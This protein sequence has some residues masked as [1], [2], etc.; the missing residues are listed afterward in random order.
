M[1][2]TSLQQSRILIIDDGVDDVE[3]LRHILEQD[4]YREIQSTTDPFAA[5]GLFG[6]FQPDLVVL[7]LLMP[8]L[9]GLKVL[10]E[11]RAIIPAGTHL[12]ILVVTADPT[13]ETR[14]EALSHG[15]SDFVTKPYDTA[16][17]R[18]RIGNHLVT[19]LLH[20]QLS[21]KQGELTVANEQ[22]L[23]EVR[24]RGQAEE[25]LR[26][27]EEHLRFTLEAT[28]VGEWELDLV[29]GASRRS[30]RHDQIFGY[31]HL[32][33]GWNY[34][35]F[36]QKHVHSDD[37]LRVE[38]SFQ[39][40]LEPGRVWES[41]CRIFRL[42]GEERF[43][44]VK[45]STRGD[46]TTPLQMSGLIMDITTRKRAEKE[47]QLRAAQVAAVA[48][49]GH[50][51]LIRNGL[52]A[53]FDD[54]VKLVAETIDVAC[55]K[56]LEL[57]PDGES[58]LLRA[59]V[60]WE[61]GLVGHATVGASKGSQAGYALL[62]G[63]P[64]IVE[65][66]RTDQRFSGSPWL[67]R[68]GII[69]GI[70]VGIGGQD[71]PFGVLSAYS[72]TPRIFTEDDIHFLQAIANL[73]AAAVERSLIEKTLHEAKEAAECANAAKSEFLSR[74]SHEL[75]TPLSAILG[76]G[77]LLEMDGRAPEEADNID[78]ILKA[79]HH[80]L[81]LIN[82]VLDISRIEAGRLDLT[83]QSF[84]VSEVVEEALAL[85]RPLAAERDVALGNLVCDR[86]V[87][88]DRQRF[89]QV[90]LNLLSNAI[91][92][93]RQGG[94]VTLA[95]EETEG[96]KLRLAITDNGLGIAAADTCKVFTAFERLGVA[97]KVEGIGLGLVISKRLVEL[98]GGRIGVES[99]PG[100]G[101]TFWIEVPL[102]ENPV[103][104]LAQNALPPIQ[105]PKSE[106]LDSR[107]LLYIEDNL[108]NLRLITRI[109]ARRPAIQLLTAATGALG[110]KMAREHRPDLVLLDFRLPDINGDQVLAGLRAD[111]RTSEIPVVMLSA[112]ALPGKR[113][114]MLA[115]GARAFLTKPVEVRTFLGVL[116]QLLEFPAEEAG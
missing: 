17:I 19:R 92:Y 109:V 55:S 42:D 22:L 6:K 29:T 30:L 103:A 79:G 76:F 67:H 59:G 115:A 27:S 26:E 82:E 72:T 116:D 110:L 40:A 21:T 96:G 56:I 75:R 62:T 36:L 58:L 97:A 16:E 41:E 23:L 63:R 66:V 87:L 13:I 105:H 50:R 93:N 78:Q 8:G 65:D 85:V 43:I 113:E 9:N 64:V 46:A 83:I 53:L 20:L 99:A 81:G 1:R 49:L 39:A 94:R 69:S 98:M 32:V 54:A 52:P 44:W 80:L 89:K 47:L 102:A 100:E 48:A 15:A 90:V 107:T 45:A 112:D 70:S 35:I 18:A 60:G 28:G 7:D 24:D 95:A 51:A 74:M 68:H 84:H 71:R 5:I 86:S 34:E 14:I 61:D 31:D 37:R 38:A 73:L 108:S 77:Q 2:D 91:K 11:L 33:P 101:S 106:A 12:P 111:P 4:G 25:A 104:Q 10:A 3:L 114:Q 57:Q 88:I